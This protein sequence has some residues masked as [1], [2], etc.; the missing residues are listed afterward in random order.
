MLRL[1]ALLV[2][3]VVAIQIPTQAPAARKSLASSL[4]MLSSGEV[5]RQEPIAEAAG[6]AA[7]VSH[8]VD[9][10]G[11][12]ADWGTEHRSEPYPEGARGICTGWL[13]SQKGGRLCC[14]H[15]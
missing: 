13:R 1:W 10:A 9:E 8:E 7:G 6:S 5:S 3:A 12:E 15:S 11:Y 2:G 14:Y 4:T